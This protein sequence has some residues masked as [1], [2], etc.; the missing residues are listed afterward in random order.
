MILW[1]MVC[2]LLC[3]MACGLLVRKRAIPR[4]TETKTELKQEVMT[5]VSQAHQC[6]YEWTEI[7]ATCL[8][9]GRKEEICSGCG[10]RRTQ[11]RIPAL[12]H[13]FRKSIWE[14]ATCLKG[15]YYN[16]IC[17]RCGLVEC[18]SE[19]QLPHEPERITV[20]EG[21]CMEDTVIRHICRN[22]G[23][24]TDADIRYTPRIHE[25]CTLTDEEGEVTYCVRCG[26]TQ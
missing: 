23:Q 12:G 13:D 22:C 25:W 6:T 15:G 3:S 9:T 11:Y 8:E 5:G 4:E 18:V 2:A 7:A 17:E 24:Q 26:I 19:A 10:R 1:L 21:N 14:S 20:Q 16:N